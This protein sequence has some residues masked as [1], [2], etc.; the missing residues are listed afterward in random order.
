VEVSGARDLVVKDN[1]VVN[2]YE[3]RELIP[4]KDCP[5]LP[6]FHLKQVGGAAIENNVVVRR[7]SSTA[8]TCSRSSTN[9]VER[10]NQTRIDPDEALEAR[11][12]ELTARYDRD[13]RAILKEVR[14]WCAG[15]GKPR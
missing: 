8:V 6:V 12:R 7:D 10:D 9:V 13:A 14:A 11:I 3:G 5:D 4:E 1:I 2:P 15:P